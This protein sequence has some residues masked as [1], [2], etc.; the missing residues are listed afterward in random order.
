MGNKEKITKDFKMK[1]LTILLF[2]SALSWA[3]NLSDE[4]M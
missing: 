3:R 2:I 4:A 1:V